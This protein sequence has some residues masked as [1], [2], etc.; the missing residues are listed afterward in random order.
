[1]L[2]PRTTKATM[3]FSATAAPALRLAAQFATAAPAPAAPASAR[4]RLSIPPSAKPTSLT[5]SV[6]LR[7]GFRM[8]VVGLGTWRAGPGEVGAAVAEA[9]KQGYRHIDGAA[10]YQNE[11]EVGAAIR[12]WLASTGEKVSQEGSWDDC[13]GARVARCSWLISWLFSFSLV[14]HRQRES[15][16]VTSKLWNV[17]VAHQRGLVRCTEKPVNEQLVC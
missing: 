3:R 16:F 2:G 1:M 9:L 11:P 6:T 7:T 17:P 8:P 4:L 5:S 14:L 13:A 12:Q 10:V 15:L